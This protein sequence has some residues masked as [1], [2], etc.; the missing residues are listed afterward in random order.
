MFF[1]ACHTHIFQLPRG[2]K[3]NF[4]TCNIL[5]SSYRDKEE[6]EVSNVNA[7]DAVSKNNSFM[8]KKVSEKTRL[9]VNK[10]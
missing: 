7:D 3:F 1:F 2:D 5:R 9:N 10:T 4:I 8:S 6:V